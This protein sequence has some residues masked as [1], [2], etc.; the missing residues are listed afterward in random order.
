MSLAK[1]EALLN[2]HYA[3][4]KP[5]EYDMPLTYAEAVENLTLV[6]LLKRYCRVTYFKPVSSETEWMCATF[7][8]VCRELR[9]N[10]QVPH[11]AI[12]AI[13]IAR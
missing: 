12:T 11:D 10:G 6:G 3:Q 9:R 4:H 13:E 2:A 8:E 7:E 5:T 1:L